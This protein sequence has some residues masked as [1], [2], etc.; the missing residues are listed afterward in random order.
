MN[1]K[2]TIKNIC[3]SK[4]GFNS[5]IEGRKE[6]KGREEGREGRDFMCVAPLCS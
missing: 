1:N 5:Q 4:P 2:T 3:I 6:G